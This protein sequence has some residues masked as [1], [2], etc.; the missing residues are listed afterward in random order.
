MTAFQC[1]GFE[2]PL[3]MGP[4]IVRKS[5]RALPHKAQLKDEDGFVV[6]A[7]DLQNPPDIQVLFLPPNGGGGVEPVDV[8][9]MA[10]AVGLATDGNQFVFTDEGKWQFNLKL[11]NFTAPWTYTVLMERG[12]KNEY[13]I[14][15]HGEATFIIE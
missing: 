11:K 9:S 7:A 10:L 3:N 6:T 15:P 14:E 12:D 5:N 1:E 4:V 2:P 13:V 8:N